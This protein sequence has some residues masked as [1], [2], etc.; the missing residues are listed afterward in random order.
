[1]INLTDARCQ[2][3]TPKLRKWG[4][5]LEPVFGGVTQ[6]LNRVGSRYALA[7]QTPPMRIEPD[8]RRW[9]SRLQQAAQF[10]G[11][12][13]FPQVE[14]KV[15]VPGLPTVAEN[16]TG[17]MSVAIQGATPNYAIREGQWLS[18]THIGR[19]YL[20]S[21]PANVVLDGTGSGD[22]PLSVPIRSLLSVGDP[23]NL[24]APII[25]GK[26]EGDDLEWTLE[27]ARTVGL[28]FVIVERA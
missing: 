2:V 15:G 25:A 20:Y 24:T 28:S 10:G 21:C 27:M 6:E 3:G 16:V 5:E 19:S 13:E 23:V 12:F 17:G 22:V 9:I 14:F 7:V 26:I 18:I 11:Y 1:M 4:S 8:G